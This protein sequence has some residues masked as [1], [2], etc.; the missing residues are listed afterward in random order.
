M[1]S[2]LGVQ[3]IVQA[4]LELLQHTV[5]LRG[6]L[7]M[8]HGTFC[9][10]RCLLFGLC[11]VLIYQI[12]EVWHTSAAAAL[13][14]NP[15]PS[16][17]LGPEVSVE[18]KLQATLTRLYAVLQH[19]SRGLAGR[20]AKALESTVLRLLTSCATP[21]SLISQLHLCGKDDYGRP[22]QGCLSKQG[23]PLTSSHT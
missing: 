22:H 8:H 1:F 21:Y 18:Q 12:S 9:C 23:Q 14:D 15:D 13:R 17:Q 5:P 2:T 3:L 19:I 7:H 6:S 11:S 20:T 10:C 16:Q 4:G